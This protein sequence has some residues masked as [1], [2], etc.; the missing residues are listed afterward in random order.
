[1]TQLK[2]IKFQLITAFLMIVTLALAQ[3]KHSYY[4]G[5]LPAVT[6]EKSYGAGEFDVNI[7]PL[8]FQMPIHKRIDLRGTNIYNFHFGDESEIADIGLE[9]AT[10]VFLKSKENKNE[11]SSG[12]YLSPVISWGRNFID[13]HNTLILAAEPGYMFRTK[14]KFALSAHLQFGGSLF[15][16]A[17]NVDIWHQHLGIRVNLGFWN[18]FY[19]GT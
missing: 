5:L 6:K 10:P 13:E 16:Y 7:I 9:V 4:L 8:V 19:R 2:H 11:F 12:F 1:M 18:L 3:P 15:M 14:G 17:D